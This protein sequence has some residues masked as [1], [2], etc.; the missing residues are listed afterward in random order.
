[1]ENF[2]KNNDEVFNI[3]LKSLLEMQKKGNDP[4]SI[5]SFNRTDFS[6]DIIED[7]K[8]RPEE[9]KAN[10]AGRII[11]LRSMG[12]A[13]FVDILDSRGK[14]QVY[15]KSDDI[16]PE[17]YEE[18]KSF[19]VGDF[20]G[21]SGFVF[22]T[23]KDEISVH[24]QK[25]TL[26]SKSLRSLPE[27]FHGFKD[28]DLRYRQRYLDL[29]VNREVKKVFE[30]RILIIKTIRNYL[31]SLGFVE[32]ETPIMNI[33]PG[34]ASARPFITHHNALNL[35]LYLR[36]APELYLKRLIV[37][38]MEKVYEIGRLFRNE[39]VSTKHN[40]EFT[41]V[42]LYEAYSDYNDMMRITEDIIINCC[43]SV[44]DKLN[45]TYQGVEINLE[46]PFLR[47][48]MLEA[49]KKYTEVDFS[50]FLH[51]KNKILKNCEK[52]NLKVD[53]NLST[54]EILSF[55]FEEKVESNL[56]QPTFI[57]DYPVEISPLA[58]KKKEDPQFTQRFE[59]FIAGREFANA[60]SELNDPIDQRLRFEEQELKR[61]NG[62]EEANKIDEDFLT[63]LEY[64][65]P[66]TGGLG[67][68]IDRLVMLLTNSSSIKD[69]IL[70]P[71]MKSL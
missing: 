62:D 27:K 42:E 65:M 25:I 46:K 63:A 20:L 4:F 49:I 58:K 22:K 12:K 55:V 9:K 43:I 18:F 54:G 14:I 24:A 50:P 59:L 8:N 67:I 37:G 3:K 60:Y 64:G 66:P 31:D 16:G 34:G 44:N 61:K 33:I 52:I 13:S 53:G 5:S 1:M 6:E 47:L 21:I 51:D 19:N 7:F 29:I 26:L 15:V 69:V 57:Y 68:G 39:G 41:T 11:R 32:V 40:P 30:K 71:T 10:I 35:D 28:I 70:F 17:K 38:G 36:I 56:M 48:S 2:L 23:K 45:I